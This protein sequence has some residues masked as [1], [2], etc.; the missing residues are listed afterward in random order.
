MMIRAPSRTHIHHDALARCR[1]EI[2]K[3][4]QHAY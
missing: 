4:G 1:V 3:G 2:R